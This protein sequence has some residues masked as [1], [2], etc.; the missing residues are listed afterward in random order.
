MFRHNS[1]EVRKNRR[2]R[3]RREDQRVRSWNDDGE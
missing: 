2:R 3:R 1:D